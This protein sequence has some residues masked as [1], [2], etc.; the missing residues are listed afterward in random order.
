VPACVLSGGSNN[1]ILGS[2]QATIGGSNNVIIGGYGNSAAFTVR[3]I[4]MGGYQNYVRG[5]DS[6]VIGGRNNNINLVYNSGIFA[7]RSNR[8]NGSFSSDQVIIG[9]RS[10]L[11]SATANYN[12][13]FSGSSNQIIG[14][15]RSSTI[16]CGKSNSISDNNLS[17]IIG[18]SNNS[19]SSGSLVSATNTIIGSEGST[20]RAPLICFRNIILG[21][22][23]NDSNNSTSS[24]ILGGSYHYISGSDMA[25]IGGVNNKVTGS[26]DRSVIT[27]G[28]NNR[29]DGSAFDC[30]IA[31]GRSNSITDADQCFIAAGSN[32][33]ITDGDQHTILGGYDNTISSSQY[34]CSIVGGR[35]HSIAGATCNSVIIGGDNHA[36][37][38]GHNCSVII[39]GSNFNS[40][41]G[42]Q[43]N[44]GG[45]LRVKTVPIVTAGISNFWLVWDKTIGA[46]N[47]S[48][49][50]R[51]TTGRTSDERLKENIEEINTAELTNTLN[52]I[53]VIKYNKKS[54]PSRTYQNNKKYGFSA[55]NLQQVIP[56]AVVIKGYSELINDDVLGFDDTAILAYLTGICKEQQKQI[57]SQKTKIENDQSEIA[58][59][60]NQI[61][62]ILTR[63]HTLE[64]Q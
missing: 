64:S 48:V 18:G 32:N 2:Q 62:D 57:D 60:K 21:G 22:F 34:N 59:L 45:T 50:K 26:A 20:I 15:S 28:S 17:T 29:I 11:I 38:T 4:A 54:F 46:A 27:G 40:T 9:G 41:A 35:F 47:E 58:T 10:N 53:K 44:I 56:W 23:R 30:V 55:Q 61:E 19:I 31:G 6:T 37:A 24:A 1:V 52:E 12:G 39:G 63:L 25:I 43:I 51:D 13:I 49:V 36:I 7:G 8:I 16:L 5:M 3:S 33:E 42:N 14:D